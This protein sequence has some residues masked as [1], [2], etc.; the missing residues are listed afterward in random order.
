[1][2]FRYDEKL[3]AAV[4]ADSGVMIRR[5]RRQ[6]DTQQAVDERSDIRDCLLRDS[7]VSRRFARAA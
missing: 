1:L 4:D 7:T 5:P 6:P 3:H 2:A